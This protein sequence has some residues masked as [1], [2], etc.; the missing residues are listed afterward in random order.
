[1]RSLRWG[2]WEVL[3]GVDLQRDGVRRARRVVD[4]LCSQ[5]GLAL[6]VANAT[7]L[8]SNG[9]LAVRLISHLAHRMKQGDVRLETLSTVAAG[10]QP[11]RQTAGA[12]SILRQAA[13]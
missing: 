1:M 10:R 7:L 2:L 4:R 12:K 13:A 8:T 5:G 11:G 3:A 9:R 6:V